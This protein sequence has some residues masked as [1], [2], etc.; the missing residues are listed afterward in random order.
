MFFPQTQVD[1]STMKNVMM[2]FNMSPILQVVS[3]ESNC[4]DLICDSAVMF[5]GH[6]IAEWVAVLHL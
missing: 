4:E 6:L 1:I 3:L 5:A 2:G